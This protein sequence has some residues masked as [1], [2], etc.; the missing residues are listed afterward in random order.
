MGPRRSH[1]KSRNGCQSCKARKVKVSDSK[2]T[3]YLLNCVN[4]FKSV[5]KPGRTVITA[6]NTEYNVSSAMPPQAPPG[7]QCHLQLSALPASQVPSP[8]GR[9][10]HQWA[11]PRW[12]YSTTSLHQ[13][14]IQFHAAQFCKQYGKSGSR[15]S[16]SRRHS[17]SAP[18]S[19][20]PRCIWLI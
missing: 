14:A 3:I 13:P 20:F 4:T 16:V 19:L 6:S 18:S 10:P 17:Y 9:T 1:R 15:K 11:W 2:K 7:N 12:L 5:M 8:R